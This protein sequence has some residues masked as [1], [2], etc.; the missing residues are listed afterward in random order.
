MQIHIFKT[1]K[2]LKKTLFFSHIKY[3]T[4]DILYERIK[5]IIFQKWNKNDTFLLKSSQRFFKYK[6]H[7]GLNNNSVQSF[8]IENLQHFFL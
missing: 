6:Q 8:Q 3:C 5:R 1:I 2:S 4:P 7:F